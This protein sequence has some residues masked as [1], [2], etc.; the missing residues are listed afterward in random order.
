MNAG[1]IT[2]E[3]RVVD[4]ASAELR[5]IAWAIQSIDGQWHPSYMRADRLPVPKPG[6]KR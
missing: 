4:H 3:L 2:V 5:R 1:E 6:G